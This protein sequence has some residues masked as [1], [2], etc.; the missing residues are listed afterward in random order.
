MKKNVS[1]MAVVMALLA[2]LCSMQV[3]SYGAPK[4]KPAK[5][6]GRVPANY[7]QLELSEEQKNKIYDVQGKYKE[8]IDELN[9]KLRDLRAKELQEI[10]EVLTP[11]QKKKLAEIEEAAKKERLAKAEKAKAEKAAKKAEDKPAEKK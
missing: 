7:G 8:Q 6:R 5:P 4:A 2:G 11:D 9:Q 10:Q 3:V 1:R